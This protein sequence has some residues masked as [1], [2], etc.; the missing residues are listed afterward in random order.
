MIKSSENSN[1]EGWT[2]RLT[3]QTPSDIFAYSA[4]PKIYSVGDAYSPH[5]Y[6]IFQQGNPTKQDI[7]GWRFKFEFFAY[8]TKHP[9]TIPYAVGDAMKPHRFMVFPNT[10]SAN[11]DGWSHQFVFWAYPS[12]LDSCFL[13]Q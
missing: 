8:P 4:P 6:R 1:G 13:L 12:L 2:H 3:F 10:E 7:A 11:K 9:G 5:R